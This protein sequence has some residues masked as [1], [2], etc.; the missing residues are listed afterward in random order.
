MS[1]VA[2]NCHN[3]NDGARLP[4]VAGAL[5]GSPSS[6]QSGDSSGASGG[7]TIDAGG[8]GNA[9]GG[10]VE[11]NDSGPETG[12]AEG[13]SSGRG[14]P[15]NVSEGGHRQQPMSGP[16]GMGGTDDAGMSGSKDVNGGNGAGE[17]GLG[18]EANAPAAGP[19]SC[20]DPELD[21]LVPECF[22]NPT[23]YFPSLE[24]VRALG[25]GISGGQEGGFYVFTSKA[26]TNTMAIDW[27]SDNY[28]LE[29]GGLDC[30][31]AVPNPQRVAAARFGSADPQ[32]YATTACGQVYARRLFGYAPA[33]SGWSPL[34]LPAPSSVVTDVAVCL[35][36]DG[37]SQLYVADRGHVFV[38]SQ[39]AATTTAPYGD[40]QDLGPGAGP[41]IAA[42]NLA[43]GRQQLLSL[44]A[45]GHPRATEQ[46]SDEVNPEFG[47]W[48][49]FGSAD[50]PSL[51][52]IDAP[53]ANPTL[54]VF[55]IDWT[56]ELWIRCED[57]DGTLTPWQLWSDAEQPARFVALAVASAPDGP[58]TPLVVAAVGEDEG[59]YV[60][61]RIYDLWRDWQRL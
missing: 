4:G 21:S 35:N 50:V 52:D 42:A 27:T 23:G 1:L 40:W 28:G 17:G 60:R 5:V 13:G 46:S 22:S 54:E 12:A 32:V 61:A 47:S 43:D 41:I 56:G 2:L 59:V 15:S 39:A 3:F 37:L 26:D 36:R 29:W 19:P 33:W 57:T 38:R 20:R 16:S 18:G 6:G 34:D 48:H 25:I 11:S 7:S 55:A 31:D 44:D 8:D 51:L 10:S 53:Y 30:F 49:D 9:A 45:Q 14:E 24:V 58:G